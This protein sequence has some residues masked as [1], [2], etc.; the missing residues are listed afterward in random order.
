MTNATIRPATRGST[1]RRAG[2]RAGGPW[3]LGAALMGIVTALFA[4]LST[5]ALLDERAAAVWAGLSLA[6]FAVVMICLVAVRTGTGMR[7]G[8]WELGPWT[9]VWVMTTFGLATI[10]WSAPAE[11]SAA[12]I[13]VTYVV[14]AVW[15]V[16]AATAVWTAGYLSGPP[17]FVVRPAQR[18]M[19]AMSRHRIPRIRSPWTPWLLFGI[20]LVARAM[21]TATTGSFGYV[22]DAGT[23]ILALSGYR[24]LFTALGLFAPLGVAAAAIQVFGED[25]RSARFTLAVLFLA[26]IVIGALGGGK[27]SFI[28]AVLAVLIP[29][30]AARLRVPRL[31][32]LA[33]GVVFLILV[34][35][36][37]QGYR[38]TVRSDVNL[39]VAQAFS[40]APEVLDESLRI[41][42]NPGTLSES[43]GYFFTRVRLIDIPALILQ[44]TPDQIAY[45]S[46]NEILVAP[47]IGLVPRAIWPGK[48]VLDTGYQF[49]QTYY[50]TSDAFSSSAITPQGDLYRHGG[51]LV[52]L[53]G[54]TFLGMLTRLLDSVFSV[55]KNPHAIFFVLLLFPAFVKMEI[56]MVSLL[57][58]L[59]ATLVMAAVAVYVAFQPRT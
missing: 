17:R 9:L 31:A 51:W 5:A 53:V 34:V 1:L 39:T 16:M 27:Q 40:A 48:P 37:N 3:G 25:R 50:G 41:A 59:P 35:P 32:V 43:F 20:A 28:V 46:V 54:M 56:D 38:T 6:S 33:A 42:S 22:G 49:A 24:Q 29:F 2:G 58:S 12:R 19:S 18:A 36:F 15:L 14:P 30:G 26:E 57:A 10:T 8:R 7:L 21:S 55:S 11:G 23:G 4:W 52:L 44:R 45:R 13:S 47:A